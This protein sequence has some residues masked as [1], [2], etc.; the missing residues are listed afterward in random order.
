MGHVQAPVVAAVE[1]LSETVRLQ[2]P[3]QLPCEEQ[4]L[5]VAVSFAC[6]SVIHPLGLLII[7]MKVRKTLLRICLQCRFPSPSPPATP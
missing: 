1:V 4:G 5:H 3:Q 7:F 2:G 6:I